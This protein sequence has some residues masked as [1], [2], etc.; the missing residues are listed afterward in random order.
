MFKLK[1][2]LFF[3]GFLSFL[4]FPLSL[5]ANTTTHE[6]TTQYVKGSTITADVK[7]RL[8]ADS[9][10]KSLHISV[11]TVKGVVTLTGY[12]E[13]Q[14]QMDKASTI[15]KEVDG[16]VSVNNKLKIRKPSK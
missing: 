11:K 14:A 8:L 16:V 6:S 7:A 13:T 2:L 1:S 15:A 10:V 9:D 3:L 5:Y 12:V 4:S